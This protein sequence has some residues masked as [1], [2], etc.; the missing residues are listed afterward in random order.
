MKKTITAVCLIAILL[1]TLSLM[2]SAEIRTSPDV[3]SLK[4]ESYP[5]KTVYNAFEQFDSRGLVLLAT[6]ADGSV[7]KIDGDSIQV[8]YNRDVCFRV[9]DETV[10]LSYSGKSVKLPVTVN[11]ITYDLSV[12]E[13]NSISTVYNGKF[14]S[15]TELLPK[16]TGLDG[17]P[18]QMSAVGGSINAGVYDISIDFYTESKDYLTPESRVVSLT[19]QPAEITAVWENLSFTYDGKSKS[20][21][22]YFTDLAGKRVNLSVVGAATNAG[23]DYTA[24]ASLADSNYKL[25]N[26]NTTF[27]IKKADY[28]MS[29]V[30]WSAKSFTYDGNKRS[31]TLMGL[32]S[33]V[34][35]VGYSGDRAT[36]A[37]K[38]TATATLSWDKINYNTP[39]ILTHSWEIKPADYDMSGVR[40]DSASFVFDGKMHYPTLKGK[41]PT[42]A[43]GITLEYSF[44]SGACHVDDG[45]VSVII[46]FSTDSKNYN[47]P[48]DR[49][50]SVQI[51]PLGIEARWETLSFTYNG[52]EQAPTAFSDRC[53]L[54]VLGGKTGAGRYT[55][56]AVPDN[57][58][59]YVINDS[60]EYTIERAENLWTVFPENSKCY[61]GKE[62]SL[63]G[64]S[65]FGQISYTF[66]SDPE[67]KNRISSPTAKGKYYA[68]LSVSATENYGELRSEIISF[69]IVPITPISFFAVISSSDLCAFDK[70]LPTDLVC[71]VINNDGSSDAVDSSLVKVIYENGDSFRKGDSSVTLKYGN[72]TLSLPVEVGYASYDLS[73]VEWKNTYTVYDGKEKTPILSGLPE[74]IRVLEYIGSGVKDA[75]IYK[76]YAR[77]EYD[78]ENYNMP[79]LPECDFVISK[80]PIS[81]PHITAVYNGKPLSPESDSDLYTV[82][83][84]KSYTDAGKYTVTVRLTDNKNY[85]FKENSDSSANAIFEILPATIF[86]KVSDVKLHL[87]EPLGEVD[88]L[89]TGGRLFGDDR[90]SVSSYREGSRVFVRSE[91]PNYTLHVESGRLIRLPYPTLSG[92]I[93]ILCVTVAIVALFVIGWAI[94]R[95]R[96]KIAT[97]T[98][99]AKCRWH[100]RDFVAPEP[101]QMKGIRSV[102]D[103]EREKEIAEIIGGQNNEEQLNAELFSERFN[104][105]DFDVDAERADMLIT[106]SLAKSLLKKDGDVI[107]TDGNSRG[108]INVDVLSDNF[109][110]GEHVDINSL[111]DKRLIDEHISFIKILA[112]GRID[113]PLIVYANEFSL[114]AVK[115]I[116]LTGGQSIKV[117]SKP[118]REKE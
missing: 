74:G 71:S 59:Y 34:S 26:A 46:S 99:V 16:I 85:V 97:A 94:Y 107:Y 105:L 64:K 70:L 22:A 43:D 36:E 73:G 80:R 30:K 101:R 79:Q 117:T 10:T 24:T 65:K 77:V 76:V 111:K 51:K 19:I 54:S 9:G 29:L 78:K 81:I 35:V 5:D 12:L 7:K 17:I 21:T 47:I 89:I 44:S 48:S 92:G 106:D 75:G 96:R 39:P 95:N 52:E 15:Y 38:Y 23:Q 66:Y 20:P 98:A 118:K 56:R 14:Q 82:T 4:I 49:Y 113:K 6:L 100:N 41:M 91:N 104:M 55:A 57:N 61:E 63:V 37:G 116:A 2:I 115:M 72:F 11:R 84:T 109:S 27:E 114:S 1:V 62:I 87:L 110:A 67:G 40:F 93:I 25:T 83:S 90:M 53:S 88:Y 103:D 112:R 58:D 28:D 8:I 60:V 45:I 13:L 33:G 69:E 31:V 32:P 3:I 108:I 50:S 102:Q 42:G 68:V 18:L 86:V